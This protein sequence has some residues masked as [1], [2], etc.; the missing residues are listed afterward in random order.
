MS[1]KA[2]IS[3]ARETS[4]DMP[5]KDSLNQEIAIIDPASGRAIVTCRIYIPGS[6][7]YCALWISAPDCYARGAGKAGGYGYHKPSA[8]LQSAIS[9][10]GITLHGDVYGRE[11]HKRRAYI[12]GVGDSAMVE[13][14]EAIARA[15]TGKRRF[16]VHKAHP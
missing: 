7:A 9:D 6:V 2:N 3:A 11:S 13:A 4:K 12:D 14:L 5:R 8:A 15:A 10:A 16:I 1:I